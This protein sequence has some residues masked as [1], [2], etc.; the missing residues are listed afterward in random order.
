MCWSAGDGSKR[1]S[2]RLSSCPR[3]TVPLTSMQ[4][5]RGTRSCAP[6][7]RRCSPPTSGPARR[8]RVRWPGEGTASP[9]RW[10][11][12]PRPRRSPGLWDARSAPTACSADSAAA[13]WGWSTRRGTAACCAA[14]RSSSCRRKPAAM[15]WPGSASC[16]RRGPPRRS[17][18]PTSAPC[19]TSAKRIWATASGRGRFWSCPATAARPSR[20]GSPAPPCR[21][22]QPST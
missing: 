15:R 14:W 21:S 10:I 7:P 3:K 11:P 2:A 8:P 1:S 22:K 13:P 19:T 4:P 20:H 18:I 16:A 17:T 12:T 5:V 9:R 6:R